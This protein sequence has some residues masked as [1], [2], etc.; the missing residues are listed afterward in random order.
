M[1]NK[2][3]W[4]L[5]ALFLLSLLGISF[6]GGP[7]TY[8]FFWTVL[9]IPLICFIYI[10]CVIHG[11]RIYQ[12][13]DG[14][15]MVCGTPSDF[16]II[17]K[18]E[19]WFTFSS[20]RIIFYSSFSTVSEID[21]DAVYELGPHSSLQKKTKLLCRFRGDYCVGIKQIVVRDFL[22]LF[23]V[24]YKIKE[25]LS[26]VVDPAIVHLPGLNN[27]DMDMNSDRDNPY[28]RSMPDIPVREYTPGDDIR[29][30]NWKA[31]A[32]M[33]KYMVRQLCGE[34]KSGIAI[35]M[36]PGRYSKDPEN[37]LPY[38][39]KIIEQTIALT[40]YY[41]ENHIPVDVICRSAQAE[42]IPVGN[43]GEFDV[44]YEQ[45]CSYS[46]RSDC[47]LKRFLAELYGNS[48]IYGYKM[49]F[50]VIQSWSADEY[51]WIEKINAEQ[52]PVTIFLID[53]SADIK[54]P[55]IPNDDTQ[56]I[57]LSTRSYTEVMS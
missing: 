23:S 44:L 19:G 14:R 18:N 43:L 56:V 48:V 24:T 28:K 35:I 4:I 33:Q 9:M 10:F 17:L 37:Y 29:F 47:D 52:T 54:M 3:G 42:K 32:A 34:E 39:N 25:P 31:S 15:A 55:D 8:V 7:V 30:L 22:D 13:T 1:K 53:E 51:E 46:Y 50:F 36:D 11:I 12:K 2:R 27:R 20:L 16:Y 57:M 41:V 5:A 40:L 45:M 49:I 6:Y 21:G 38:E 26:V